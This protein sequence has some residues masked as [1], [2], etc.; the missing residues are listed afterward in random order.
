MYPLIMMIFELVILFVL[1]FEHI[2]EMAGV[3]RKRYLKELKKKKKKKDKH[4]KSRSIKDVVKW[5][6]A[7]RKFI[8]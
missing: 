3:Y 1:C 6:L 5:C 2:S 8:V 7:H 4:K